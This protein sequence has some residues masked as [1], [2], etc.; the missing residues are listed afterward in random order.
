VLLGKAIPV[1][2]RRT[3]AGY[4]CGQGRRRP[5]SA[6]GVWEAADSLGL[7]RLV[8][9]HRQV[10]RL[11]SFHL[12]ATYDAE[13]QAAR[14]DV[15]PHREV[16]RLAAIVPTHPA[17]VTAHQR[18]LEDTEADLSGAEDRRDQLIAALAQHS[19]DYRELRAEWPTVELG[20]RREI[21]RAGID[22]VVVR[23]ASGQVPSS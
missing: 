6:A 8:G 7:E 10:D 3:S 16:E 12:R 14:E 9:A 4:R 23:R 5:R 20:E 1:L 17:A 11:E 21:L 18:A 2:A 13:V 22:E 19:P 15:R